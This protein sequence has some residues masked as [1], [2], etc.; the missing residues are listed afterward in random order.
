MMTRIQIP[1]QQFFRTMTLTS[2]R[3]RDTSPLTSNYQMQQRTLHRIRDDLA[4]Q[5]RDQL[6][7]EI[8][9]E[10]QELQDSLDR[11]H[12]VV[13]YCTYSTYVPYSLS[14]YRVLNS[15]TASAPLAL[16]SRHIVI[17]LL[18]IA[19]YPLAC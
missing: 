9:I 13:L 6:N 10:I 11:R 4:R 14:P 3:I 8:E 2:V 18:S 16:L 15:D 5:V 1:H 17:S 12:S 19:S 7:A